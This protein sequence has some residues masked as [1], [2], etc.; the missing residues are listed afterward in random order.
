MFQCPAVEYQIKPLLKVFFNRAV[1][2][3]DEIRSFKR[4][5]VQRMNL[6]GSKSTEERFGKTH[7]Q[8]AG[9]KH[10]AFQS[11]TRRTSL[12]LCRI[13][14][15]ILLQDH[16]GVATVR[17]KPPRQEQKSR[18]IDLNAHSTKGGGSS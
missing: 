9:R 6:S 5:G 15:Q 7:V 10:F 13:D 14:V 12:H 2:I 18:G 17:A 4:G 11:R 16:Q 8:R 3:M 1:Q